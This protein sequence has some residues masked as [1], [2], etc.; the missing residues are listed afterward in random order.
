M[1]NR[2]DHRGKGRLNSHENDGWRKKPLVSDSSN[3]ILPTNSDNIPLQESASME[4]IERSG[5]NSQ[6]KD[7]GESVPPVSD[8]SDGHSQVISYFIIIH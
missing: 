4:S 2:A 3:V 7:G 5:S 6:G 8:R 1:H